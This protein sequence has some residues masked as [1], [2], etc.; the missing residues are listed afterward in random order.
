M[1]VG[2]GGSISAEIS[3]GNAPVGLPGRVFFCLSA[4]RLV[5]LET[6]GI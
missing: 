6:S 4:L 2:M 1:F 5:K 3:A